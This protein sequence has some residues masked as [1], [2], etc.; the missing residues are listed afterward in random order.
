MW[1]RDF[2]VLKLFDPRNKAFVGICLRGGWEVAS[3]QW[4]KLNIRG[5]NQMLW[6]CR[7]QWLFVSQWKFWENLDIANIEKLWQLVTSSL[8][9]WKDQS[10]DYHGSL[11]GPL[12]PGCFCS[13]QTVLL[14]KTECPPRK[15]AKHPMICVVKYMLLG[16]QRREGSLDA[17]KF[18]IDYWT[19]WKHRWCLQHFLFLAVGTLERIEKSWMW[20]TGSADGDGERA[21]PTVLNPRLMGSSSQKN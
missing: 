16:K 20:T 17:P 3:H 2:N 13:W 15:P 19:T 1:E 10:V 8:E 21:W 4:S 7:Q 14:N 9:V 5:E 6:K 12:L 18:W 11:T